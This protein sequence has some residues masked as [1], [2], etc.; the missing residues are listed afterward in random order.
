[1]KDCVFCKILRNESPAHKI[2]ENENFFAFLTLGSLNPGHTLLK[3]KSHV[4]YIFDL[5]EP[6]YSAIFQTAKLLSEPLRNAMKARRVGVIIEGFTVPHVHLHLVP[7]HDED[8]IDPRRMTKMQANE[9]A[10]I[11]A[12]I[13]REIDF[14]TLLL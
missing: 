9:L 14:S 7:L 5:P 10:E 2:W 1:M 6:L 3:P 8:E 4:D 12:T 13:K 11:A